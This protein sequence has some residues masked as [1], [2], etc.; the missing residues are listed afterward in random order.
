LIYYSAAFLAVFV[1][2]PRLPNLARPY[3]AFGY[4]VTTGIVL[5]GSLGFSRLSP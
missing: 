5:I 1:L 3:K 4:P 2:R